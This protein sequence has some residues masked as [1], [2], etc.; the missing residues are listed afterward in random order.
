[1]QLLA[2]HLVLLAAHLVLLEAH[3]LLKLI[4]VRLSPHI[5]SSLAYSGVWFDY[6]LMLCV[7]CSG[8]AVSSVL[9]DM[10]SQEAT[11][12]PAPTL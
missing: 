4:G 12:P 8:H 9:P 2:A 6:A 7:G 5:H 3:P 11:R 1:M 10:A